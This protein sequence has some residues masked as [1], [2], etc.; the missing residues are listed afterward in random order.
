MKLA[1]FIY[2]DG[3]AVGIDITRASVHKYDPDQPRD[4]HG[5]F[6]S[7]DGSA[8]SSEWS[9]TMTRDEADK[10]AANSAIKESL[11]HGTTFE[12]ADSIKQNGFAQGQSGMQGPAI[13]LGTEF[14][15]WHF[16]SG[17]ALLECRVNVT[18]PASLD[19][20]K[21]IAREKFGANEEKWPSDAIRSVALD[22]GYDAVIN[23]GEYLLFDKHNITVVGD[24]LKKT[25][26]SDLS[27]YDPDQPRNEKGEFA[28]GDGSG[29]VTRPIPSLE[30]LDSFP[31]VSGPLGSNGGKWVQDPDTKV[32]YLIKP[33]DSYAHA[34]NEVM[35][36]AVYRAAG[37][38][39]P[40]TGMVQSGGKWYV[41][42]EKIEGLSWQSASWWKQSPEIQTEAA[43]GFG[44]DALLSHW[45]VHGMGADNTL[46]D[47]QNR[48]VR[49]EA[50][51][52]MAFRAQGTEKPSFAV[53][54]PWVEVQSMRESNQG[55][56][57]YGDMTDAQVAKSLEL[58]ANLDIA[59][60][61]QTVEKL[62]VSPIIADSWART[63]AWRQSLIPDI[64]RK[65]TT[66]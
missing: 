22:N 19:D 16:A 14:A 61:T 25:I 39:F 38:P 18:N 2:A 47:G 13:Y 5:R 17:Q 56:A 33:A 57:M 46:L 23:G 34:A 62:G 36:G 30:K 65:L 9:S 45:D 35:S 10:W 60:I 21:S 51:G 29:D 58:A 59:K 8:A 3:D 53:G 20:I 55:R 41:V 15:A 6:G 31:K 49:I 37:L 42:S 28:S 64:V 50:G 48:P 1:R 26:A 32:K 12:R 66:K 4:E 27:K 44:I 24:N 63:L 7:G 40:N 11:Y 54:K 43:R 52:A